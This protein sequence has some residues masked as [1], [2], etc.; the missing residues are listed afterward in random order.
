MIDLKVAACSQRPCACGGPAGNTVQNA[1]ERVQP[2]AG[3]LSRGHEWL[4]GWAH[5][6]RAQQHEYVS[7]ERSEHA[8]GL[9]SVR[10]VRRRC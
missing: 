4:S 9:V 5:F 6:G 1:S 8:V 10:K 2:G 3:R 7:D